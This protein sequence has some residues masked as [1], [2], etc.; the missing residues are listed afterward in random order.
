MFRYLSRIPA[1]L[2]LILI[3]VTTGCDKGPEY[4]PPEVIRQD[5]PSMSAK[6]IDI[7]F[8]DSGK[9]EARLISPLLNR[10]GGEAPYVELPEGFII[11]V[12][13]SLQR[14]SSTITGKKGV[15]RDYARVMEA[16]GNVIVRNEIKKEQLVTEHLIWDEN[17]RRI[18]SDVMVTITRPGQLITGTSME[19]NDTFTRYTITNMSGEMVVNNDS[20]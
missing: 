12:Y 1:S 14:V 9:V 15:R 3:F 17:R 6:N 13:D 5:A 4:S 16:W 8:S 7:L 19:S 18:W 11:Y 10:Y 20:I 2:F